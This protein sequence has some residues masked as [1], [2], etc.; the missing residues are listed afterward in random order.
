[1]S[2]TASEPGLSALYHFQENINSISSLLHIYGNRIQQYYRRAKDIT[3][4]VAIKAACAYLEFMVRF[5][6]STRIILQFVA[7][8]S[9]LVHI[10][11]IVA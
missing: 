8:L 4:H 3:T 11:A 5:T 2:G 7:F 9:F 1:M 6:T 10:S